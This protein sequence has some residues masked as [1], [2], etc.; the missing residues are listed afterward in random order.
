MGFNSAFKGLIR[1]NQ[2]F[3]YGAA[4]HPQVREYLVELYVG[5]CGIARVSVEEDY[6]S[7]SLEHKNLHHLRDL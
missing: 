2:F 6:I 1:E 5:I 4:S 3:I 7:G